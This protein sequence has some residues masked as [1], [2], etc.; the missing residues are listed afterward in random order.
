MYVRKT[1]CLNG[2]FSFTIQNGVT[3]LK[4]NNYKD[5]YSTL[6]YRAE[7]IIHTITIHELIYIHINIYT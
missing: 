4:D 1:T 7:Q 6:Q 3:P 5:T 2:F